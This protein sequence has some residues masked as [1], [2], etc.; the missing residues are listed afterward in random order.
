M[1]GI[2]P[3][4]HMSVKPEFVFDVCH[5]VYAAA[6][7][8]AEGIAL[9]DP[10]KIPSDHLWR[11]HKPPTGQEFAADFAIACKRALAG[12]SNSPRLILCGLYYLDLLPYARARQQMGIREDVW[13]AWT[14]I[15]R[16]KVGALLLAKGMFPPRQYFSECSVPMETDDVEIKRRA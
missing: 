16:H 9:I 7:A 1:S 4:A 5:D 3:G 11:S 12:A 13:V 14:D 8:D 6:M 10:T 15:I 2:P